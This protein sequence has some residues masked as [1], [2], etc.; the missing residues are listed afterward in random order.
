MLHN[1]IQSETETAPASLYALSKVVFQAVGSTSAVSFT[2]NQL[3]SRITCTELSNQLTKLY[4][5]LE[6][7]TMADYEKKI[8][9]LRLSENSNEE[10]GNKPFENRSHRNI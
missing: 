3:Q 9:D 1:Q 7:R 6:V 8:E 2:A 4:E 5:A 10:T